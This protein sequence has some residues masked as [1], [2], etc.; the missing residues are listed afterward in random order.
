MNMKR[1]IVKKFLT[2]SIALLLIAGLVSLAKTADIDTV[3]N[4]YATSYPKDRHM[5]MASNGTIAVL[6]YDGEIRAKKSTDYGDTW[7][8]LAGGAG[9]TIIEGG[10]SGS[11]GYDFSICPDGEDNIYVAYQKDQRIYF[12]KLTYSASDK[13]WTQGERKIVEEDYAAGNP[14]IVRESGG[15]IWVAYAYSD[16]A[17]IARQVKA[18]FSTNEFQT[19]TETVVFSEWG[20]GVIYYYP[21]L[22]IRNGNPFL[23]YEDDSDLDFKWSYWT[24]SSWSSPAIIPTASPDWFSVDF[25][26]AIV[27]NDVHIV[28][29]RGSSSIDHTYYNGTWQPA[30]TLSS[31]FLDQNPN[32][33]ASNSELWCFISQD[34][35]SW[36]QNIAYK[37]WSGTWDAGWTTIT[38]EGTTNVYPTTLATSLDYIPIAWTAQGSWSSIVRF[39]GINIGPAVDTRIDSY[40][41]DPTNSTSA[42]FTFSA[43]KNGCEFSYQLDGS[44]WS[45]YSTSTSKS[46][47][48]L[49]EGSH[50][51][52]VRAKDRAGSV[53]PTPATY[54]WR[55]DI[56]APDTSIDSYPPDPTDNTSATFTFSAN[57]SGCEFSYR[58][59]G[60]G[61]SGYG[62]S[63]SKSYIGLS[64]GSHTFE[65]KAKDKAG[66]EDPTPPSYTWVIDKTAPVA[67]VVN[68]PTHPNQNQWYANNDP[69]FNWSASDISGISG[70]SYEFDQ[71]PSTIPDDTSEGTATSKDYTDVPDGTW[72]F[73]VKAQNG[74]GLWGDTAHYR[75]NID[76]SAPG[77]PVVNSPTHPNQGTWYSN[78]DP[79]FNW[80][81]SDISGITGYS[82]VLDQN[83]ATI[84]DDTSEGA[85]TSKDYT[86]VG[87]GIWYFHIKAQNGSG[88]WGET[89]HYRINIDASGPEAP[90]V[91][92]LTHPVQTT[93]YANDDPSFIWSATDI[94]AITGYSYVL[95]QNPG[96]IPDDG[97]EGTGTSKNYS[98]VVE[99]T[100]YFHVKAQNGSGLWGDTAHYRIN[101]DTSAPG[102]PV[103]DSPTHPNQGTWYANNDPSFNWSASDISGIT[104][105]SYLLDQNPGTIPDNT[106]EGAGTSISYTDIV[107]GTWYFHVKAQNGSGL[108]GET[109]H[110]R[111]N[112][113][114]SGPEAPV[115]NSL[116]HPDQG[117]WYN[118]N[119][120]SFI[121]SASDISG[122]TG[123]SY[124]LDQNPGT[125]P[126]DSSEGTGTSKGYADV[127]DGT[128]YFHVKAKDG[129]GLWGDT[130]HYRINIDTSAPVAPVVNS[131]THPDQDVW[132][133]NND[134]SFIWSASDISGIIGYSYLLDQTPDT[135][136]D[137]SS[138]GT[139]TSRS[140][141]D[142]A[143]GT[144]YFHVKAQNGSGLWGDTAHYRVRINTS[145]PLAPVVN[146]PT[147]PDQNSWYT[148][149]DPSFDWTC[150]DPSGIAGYSYLL[151]ENSWTVP[152]NIS[153]GTGT[154]TNYTDVL[155][156]TW[157][158]HV[159]A[160]NGLG[161]WGDTAHY[162]INI[163][164]SGPAA[165]VVNSL[166]HP[167]QGTWYNHNDP[168]FIWSASDISGI[169]GYSYVL[170]QNP[171]TIPDEGSEGAGTSTNYTDVSD[172][173]WYFHVR[174]KDGSGLWGDTAHYKIN[175]DTSAPVAPVVN[176][177]THPDQ[178]DWYANN[179]PS[180]DWSASD[181]SGITGYSYV[182]DQNPGTIPDNTSE[183][184]ATSKNYTDVVDGTWYFHIKAQNGSGLWGETTHY[185]INIDASGPAAPAVNSPTH[186]DQNTWYAN[187]DPSFDWSASDP[188]GMTG[189]SYLLDQNPGTVPDDISEGSGT[190]TSY[191]DV[192][193]GTWWFHVKARNGSKPLG[194][195]GGTA[196]YRINIDRSGPEVPVVNSPTHPDQS[197]WYNNND[198]SFIW[199]ASDGSGISG[200][201]YVLDQT[202]G[203]I[204]DDS[205]EGAATSKNYTDVGSGVWYFHV[206][207]R[208]GSGLWGESAHYRINID[209]TVPGAPV[210]NSPTHPDQDV[211]YNNNDP[212]FIWSASDISGITGYSYLLD[213]T[214]DTI[215]DNS[216]EGTA[217]SR[218]YT[219]VPNGTWYFHVKAQNGSDLWGDTA[220]YRVRINTSGPLAPVVNSPTHPN[221]NDW[222]ANN[223]PSF[224]WSA[225]DPSGITG[226]SYLLD[227]N[228]G[229]LPDDVSEG[230]GTSRSYTDLTDGTWYF[231]VKAR[232][233]PG[234]W[235]DTAH[236]RVN[237][238]TSEPGPPV[239]NSPTHPDQSTWYNNNDP[240]FN[241]S[242]SD[243]S[244]ILGYS[245][246]LDQNLGTIPDDISEGTGTSTSY[247]DVPDGT[248]YFHVKAR[249][250]SG[251]WGPTA[252]YRVNIRI[253]PAFA[254]YR[255]TS[256]V[257]SARTIDPLRL[258]IELVDAVTGQPKAEANNSFEL[259]AC[260]VDLKDAPGKW[261][262]ADPLVL[263]NGRAAIWVTY[264]TVGTIL[265]GVRDNLGNTPA[266]TDPIEIWPA[267][268]RYELSAPA[269]VEAGKEFPLTVK[270]VDSGAGNIVTPAKYARWVRLVAYSSP[271]AE[272][273]A[274][275]ELKVKRFNLQRGITIVPQ[276]Y[277]L[278]QKIY[279][280]AFDA[281][282]Y[283]PQSET[284]V[285]VEIEV[286]G[287][288]KTVLKLDGG[289]NEMNAALYVTPTTRVI[290]ESVSDI[291]AEKILYRDNE[292]DWKTYGEPFTLSP[293]RHV[294][295]YYGIDKYGNE[296]EI[297]RSKPIY[298]SFFGG[299]GVSNRPN[300]F[301]AG[302]EPTL[303]EYNL[304]EPS[305]V[306]ITIYDIFGQEVWRENYAAG[307]NGGRK[308]NIVVW[309]GRNLSGK[310]VAN[311][312]YICRVWIEKEK[313][314]MVRKIAVAK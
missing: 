29:K 21:V 271:V 196:H 120:P 206:K 19:K 210:V 126:D 55:I 197:S 88:L 193:D 234:L 309:D 2:L 73:H 1:E 268:L 265:F 237:I 38:A 146:S 226:Y 99:G 208:N 121:W 176:S 90:V 253:S 6:Y 36:G 41:P 159:K 200:Y 133:N 297:N 214:P 165:P 231:H 251:L 25:S 191:T 194:L 198:P 107:E 244:G 60:G 175:I 183:G 182:L 184:T 112:I 122:I 239:V 312:G 170:D 5:V 233:G 173:T 118:N 96:T 255:I 130:A 26:V 254:N 157:W 166:T 42:T 111:I 144:W 302:K 141:T 285:R 227:Q 308:S 85:N 32:L 260:T 44:G 220:H 215:P 136:P 48:D 145:G 97:S 247:T 301:K 221:Q 12:K 100:W 282:Q 171:G 104:G 81:A 241:W 129:S 262:T 310:V 95:D 300:P 192:G 284:L 8:N 272:I 86:D 223:D 82:Y 172:G 277:N 163:D 299:D 283:D 296:E 10:G 258:I 306:I 30:Q 199:S 167:D 259:T 147:H 232:N 13:T 138:E 40:P 39:H 238:D 91:N 105:Y 249:N 65:V 50:T 69:S 114:V 9:F 201:S 278:A 243:I 47:I 117:T 66:N 135:I 20:T 211:W 142:I 261:N 305:S 16:S 287:A 160:R 79:S 46:Y 92:S 17:S 151:D 34:S 212:S 224:D 68:S 103:V 132:Y 179:D 207:A 273:L 169:T 240:S 110:Y 7:T 269:R 51:F 76:T 202:P 177:P 161:V 235:G 58:L 290:I 288:P 228:P 101:I 62:T 102:A 148:N 35:R 289:C 108:W 246:L 23:I 298:V 276:S 292:S 311:G 59:D 205:S 24:G 83:L 116:T 219:D 291:V 274:E 203:T 78:N 156:G 15:K 204:P 286:I 71:N 188:S 185:R 218:S 154:S 266:Y 54:T 217:T 180:F 164:K 270:L 125:I 216:S 195:W 128:W 137:N 153:E 264:D 263:N 275:G 314:H 52:E 33:T 252:H 113:D 294:I 281:S 75:I 57:E 93:W 143:N 242:A 225:S 304:K 257:S 293:G 168:S 72:Y 77:A 222:Y 43:N 94:S 267:G 84:P 89:A 3:S 162:R 87:N 115:V 229:T 63:T 280:E 18:T 209:A 119:D 295:E 152:D 56:T 213:Q 248:W 236:Y 74:V 11:V 140:Y 155:D 80:T 139:A 31:W 53:D 123:Y 279:I 303:I 109:A 256:T 158:F 174:A 190:S 64:E 37:K 313:R 27:G 250:G 178:N 149:N 124:V 131:P 61:W 14:S 181:I 22:V 49:I 106:S 4:S 245:Y 28:F 127:S 134:P 70:Y 45:E 230:A 307:E 150:S 98:D 189:Y 186:P 187:N 67:P